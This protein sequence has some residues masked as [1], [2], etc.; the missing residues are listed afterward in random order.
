MYKNWDKITISSNSVYPKKHDS[1]H[2]WSNNVFLKKYL[3]SNI[4]SLVILYENRVIYEK[5]GD[6]ANIV[7][8]GD[9]L[10]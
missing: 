4:F 8:L 5:Q 6:L 10:G 2:F 7:C 9:L 3:D 1:L